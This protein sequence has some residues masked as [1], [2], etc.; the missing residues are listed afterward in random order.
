MPYPL[1]HG[2]IYTIRALLSMTTWTDFIQA[3]RRSTKAMSGR[4]NVVLCTKI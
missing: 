4:K 1:G 2:A 3:A